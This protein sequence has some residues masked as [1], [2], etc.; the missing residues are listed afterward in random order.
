MTRNFAVLVALIAALAGALSSAEPVKLIAHRGGIVD[1]RYAENS[2]ASLEAAIQRGYWMAEVDV[3][4][5]KDGRLVMQH[6]PDFERF[7]GVKRL[8]AGMTW[9]EIQRLRSKPGNTRPLEFHELAALAKGRIQ[10]MVDTKEPAHPEAFY[11]SME[12]ALRD[13]GLLENAFFIGTEESRRRF[14]GKAR[15]GLD[16]KALEA[17]MARGEDTRRLYFLFEHGTTLDEPGLRLAAKAGVPPVVSIN[18]FHYDGRD[19]WKG[20]ESDIRRLRKLGMTYFQIDSV[21]D[22]WLTP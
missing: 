20:A 8:V 14:H 18:I 22:K 21:Y 15:I 19:H 11:A 7:Y 4:E 16:R 1:E 6:D 10:F 12:K 9:A 13:N 5:S 3:R 2:A 17:A